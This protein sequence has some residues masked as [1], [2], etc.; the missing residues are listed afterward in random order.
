MQGLLWSGVDICSLLVVLLG[1][2]FWRHCFVFLRS[3]H[4]FGRFDHIIDTCWS[5][6]RPEALSLS[7]S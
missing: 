4:I 3:W 2:G 5:K 7:R 6:I 1:I